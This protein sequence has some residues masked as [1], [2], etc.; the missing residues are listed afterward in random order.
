MTI[1]YREKLH[2]NIKQIQWKFFIYLS[3]KTD[4]IKYQLIYFSP[5]PPSLTIVWNIPVPLHSY[6]T[7]VEHGSNHPQAGQ[8]QWREQTF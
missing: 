6:L 7:T 3:K 2:D 4:F 1:F 8:G 5:F